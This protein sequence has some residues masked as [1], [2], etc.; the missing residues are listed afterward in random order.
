MRILFVNK[1]LYQR[2]GAETYVIKLGRQMSE[3]GHE[4][5]YFGMAD[6]RNILGNSADAYTDNI[7]FHSSSLKYITYPV[8]IIYSPSA[9][10]IEKTAGKCRG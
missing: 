8:T 10:R 5:Q 7:D 2:G 4:V 9:A 6:E 1:Y 3:M